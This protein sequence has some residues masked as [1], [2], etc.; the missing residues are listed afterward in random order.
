MD[1]PYTPG[2]K[3]TMLLPGVSVRFTQAD[4]SGNGYQYQLE[5][6]GG[7]NR[8]GAVY[9]FDGSFRQEQGLPDRILLESY[10]VDQSGQ[11]QARG[12]FGPLYPM[13]GGMAMGSGGFKPGQKIAA[14]RYE[15][16]VHPR[17]QQL[18]FVVTDITTPDAP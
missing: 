7:S 18:P 11:P 4:F 5:P 14:L 2:G 13:I 6:A 15:I 16:A 3:G 9:S 17:E 12:R 10:L 8:A 1:V